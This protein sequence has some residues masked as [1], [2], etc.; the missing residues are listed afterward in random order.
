MDTYTGD[1]GDTEGCNEYLSQLEWTLANTNY[2]CSSADVF[3]LT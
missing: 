3:M 2:P 1:G